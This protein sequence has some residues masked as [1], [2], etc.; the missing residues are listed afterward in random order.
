M[1]SFKLTEQFLKDLEK[2]GI[3]EDIVKDLASIADQKFASKHEFL[4]EIKKPLGQKPA[5]K[6]KRKIVIPPIISR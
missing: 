6:Y 3:P 1:A 2:K 4:D 5:Q